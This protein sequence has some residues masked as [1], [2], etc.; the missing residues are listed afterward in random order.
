M[1]NVGGALLVG[2]HQHQL[3]C[4]AE[5]REEGRSFRIVNLAITCLMGNCGLLQ[6][7]PPIGMGWCPYLLV[8]LSTVA[9]STPVHS[10]HCWSTGQRS[11]MCQGRWN[12]Y[13]SI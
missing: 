5:C 2:E 10:D 13:S 3:P 4:E 1:P 8:R 11:H 7:V 9:D 6:R 12:P